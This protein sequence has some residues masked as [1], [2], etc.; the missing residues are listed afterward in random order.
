M[1]AYQIQSLVQEISFDCLL[2]LICMRSMRRNFDS[3]IH[4]SGIKIVFDEETP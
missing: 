3:Y 4:K 1:Y 2:N